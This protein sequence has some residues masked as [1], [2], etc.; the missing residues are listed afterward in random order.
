[1]TNRPFVCCNCLNKWFSVYFDF[2]AEFIYKN[3]F[4]DQRF[5]SWNYIFEYMPIREI[6]ETNIQPGLDKSIFRM[7]LECERK[8]KWILLVVLNRMLSK[9]YNLP[10]KK[11]TTKPMFLGLWMKNKLGFLVLGLAPWLFVCDGL[12]ATV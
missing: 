4:Q 11:S 10:K 6:S 2:F 1:M 3:Y 12:V 5:K 8:A 9:I 7:Q